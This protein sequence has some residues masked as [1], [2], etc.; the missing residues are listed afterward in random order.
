MTS[1]KPPVPDIVAEITNLLADAQLGA[2]QA[3][4][5]VALRADGGIMRGRCSAPDQSRAEL[6]IA[7]GD[8]WFSVQ[9]DRADL[10]V[11]MPREE[12]NQS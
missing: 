1:P 10:Y 2:V 5:F 7:I 11:D 12:G 6:D 9:E 4:A 3:V 8:L